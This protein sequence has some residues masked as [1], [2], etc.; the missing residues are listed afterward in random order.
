MA[1]APAYPAY[2]VSV[3]NSTA[4]VLRARPLGSGRRSTSA[5]CRTRSSPR[6]S[7]I[8][9]ADAA[10]RCAARARLAQPRR[11]GRPA[12]RATRPTDGGCALEL[13]PARWALRLIPDDAAQSLVGAVRGPRRR[14]AL[15][16]RAAA[17]PGWPRGP[18]AGRSARAGRS[19]STRTRPQTMRA[20]AAR[21]VVGR[22]RADADRG[23]RAAAERGRAA[24]RPGLAARR[25]RPSSPTTSTTSYAWWPADVEQ[26][27]ARGRRAAAPDGH[28]ARWHDR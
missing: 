22:G 23:A 27:P 26:W 28:A 17:R 6:P 9:A 20:R 19:R 3:A 13:Q 24:R 12:R 10:L 14:R 21:G 16:G 7:A 2:R 15:A 8:E 4:P 1:R 18:A 5:G 25:R 11:P